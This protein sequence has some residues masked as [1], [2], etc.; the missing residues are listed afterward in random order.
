[1]NFM[2][3]L[4]LIGSLLA[5]SGCGGFLSGLNADQE[6]SQP[7]P[8]RTIELP[9]VAPSADG[10]SYYGRLPLT[11]ERGSL[12]GSVPVAIQ[13][14]CPAGQQIS[15]TCEVTR[16]FTDSSKDAADYS[17]FQSICYEP[18]TSRR[19]GYGPC[20]VGA[21]ICA[22]T[23]PR[24]YDADGDSPATPEATSATFAF[25]ARCVPVSR[26]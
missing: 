7:A 15:G 4:P 16:R 3:N 8:V 20:Q 12:K 23:L 25:S 5:V 10:S 6:S 18:G 21:L 14:A 11:Y 17:V 13:L 2:T 9:A 24:A 26:P 22:T 1:M 19:R